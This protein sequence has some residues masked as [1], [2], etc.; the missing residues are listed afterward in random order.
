MLF[1]LFA[2]FVS[3]CALCLVA[4]REWRHSYDPEPGARR[5]SLLHL[6]G[7]WLRLAMLFAVLAALLAA[8]P[9]V[10]AVVLAMVCGQVWAVY[11]TLDLVAWKYLN[12]PLFRVARYMPV[13]A[14]DAD[15]LRNLS[16]AVRTFVPLG[17]YLR[18]SGASAVAMFACAGPLH[19]THPVALLVLAGA[20]LSAAIALH[21]RAGRVAARIAVRPSERAFLAVDDS[22]QDGCLA[23]ADRSGACKP[24]AQL[25]GAAPHVLIVL[26]ESA[27]GD[28]TCHGGL[29]LAEAIC[30]ASGDAADWLRP[31]N[32]VT[33]SSCTDIA[34]PCLFTGCAPQDSV[35]T[36][37]RLPLLFDLAKARG[38]TTLFYSAST[39]RWG[40][41]E[42]FF[43]VGGGAIDDLATPH[44]TGLPLSH[45]LGCDDYLMAELLRERILGT[46]G[47]LFIVLYTYGL[48]LP[49]QNDSAGP[50]PDHITDR[51]SRAAHIV[52]EAHRMVFDAL[53][54]TG[55]YDDT[56][57]LSVG[58]HGETFGVDG[59]DRSCKASRLTKLSDNVTRPLFVIKPPAR[60]DP[61][62]RAGLEA[63]M[64]RMV[65]L[66]D[67][68]PT[69]ASVLEV[70]LA[71]D[72][73]PYHGY[74]LTGAEV[75]KDRLH[76]TLTV[77]DWRAWPQ[78][79]VMLAQ[80]DMRVCVDY[81][82]TTSLC[83]GGDGQPL[84][85]ALHAATDA[86]F[87]QAMTAPVVRKA[88]ARVFRDKLHNRDR[89]Q[90]VRFA[91]VVPEV[92]RPR[93][94]TGGKDM[95]F[96]TDIMMSD[97]GSGRLHYAGSR[98][99][100]RG[101]GLRPR[102]RGIMV[103]GPYVDL[104]AGRYSASF[105]FAPGARRRPLLVDVCAPGLSGS[106]V[107]GFGVSGCG[108]SGFVAK[109]V[110]RLD[111]RRLATIEFQLSQPTEGLEVR[112]HSNDGFSGIC[113]GLFLTQ[114]GIDA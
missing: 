21:G 24:K 67:I 78:A 51:R 53:R 20:L 63:N 76:Y 97:L 35:G 43:G 86:L 111:D 28:V 15:A 101:F 90:A 110:A 66:I 57:I 37:H 65:S 80:R 30:A 112:L 50:I 23:A 109:E 48:H 92:P 32:P 25:S 58:D 77:N 94:V 88:I 64:D 39:L 26:N 83:C 18:L 59:S 62:R 107:S 82:T 45:E 54:Q 12:L 4:R 93:A 13:K 16:N 102:D 70:E 2:P 60:L 73:P 95:F 7:L 6:A 114:T 17:A 27:G 72:L 31:Q 3:I 5:E 98:H 89:L 56:L 10:G 38:M 84:P 104:P 91:Q 69:L 74:D 11:E 106:G 41:F 113:Q 79:A 68:A 22:R 34:L 52:T 103:Y 85:P 8:V 81:Q 96:G 44:S 47:R 108:V 100:A 14:A 36:L 49:F 46:D 105:V 75:P 55:R 42:A 99:D 1:V 40:N 71:A 33:P 19:L 29:S 9:S 61:A 87:A